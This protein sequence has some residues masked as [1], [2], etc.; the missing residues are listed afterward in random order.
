MIFAF[1]EYYQKVST[2][3]PRVAGVLSIGFQCSF[4]LLLL[5]SSA[6]AL[7]R[8]NLS[9]LLVGAIILQRAMGVLWSSLSW[10]PAVSLSGAT[11]FWAISVNPRL[12]TA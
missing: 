2:E 10:S 9:A 6:A 12:C 3:N 4:S 11:P 1:V 5:N 7:P 8:R